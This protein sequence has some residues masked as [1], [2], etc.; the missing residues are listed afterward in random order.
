MQ[1]EDL[2]YIIEKVMIETRQWANT[3][4]EYKVCDVL[5]KLVAGLREADRATNN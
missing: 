2:A 1:F 5:E 3:E 4:A